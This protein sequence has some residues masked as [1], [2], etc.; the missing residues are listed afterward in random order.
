MHKH[1]RP[2]TTFSDFCLVFSFVL[3][4]H[5]WGHKSQFEELCEGGLEFD[6][7]VE[8]EF[9]ILSW[10]RIQR[11]GLG[12]L[13]VASKVILS[14]TASLSRGSS[15]WDIYQQSVFLNKGVG[16]NFNTYQLFSAVFA[17]QVGTVA[18]TPWTMRAKDGKVAFYL[19]WSLLITAYYKLR[20][21]F[22]LLVLVNVA[23]LAALMLFLRL[24]H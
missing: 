18:R 21:D 22:R 11:L 12:T 9:L 8:N 2:F 15:G 4:K 13:R 16:D 20:F 1:N 6:K 23:D 7:V 10:W 14:I 24:H 17:F 3:P 5:T 19:F